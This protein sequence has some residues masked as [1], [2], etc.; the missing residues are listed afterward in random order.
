[1][2]ACAYIVTRNS[3][4]PMAVPEPVAETPEA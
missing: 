4:P 1:V 3:V 2:P